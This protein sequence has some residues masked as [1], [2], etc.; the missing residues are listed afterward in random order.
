MGAERPKER[1]TA[2]Q[3]TAKKKAGEKIVCCTAYDYPGALC[4]DAAGVDLVLVGDSL[5]NVIAGEPTTLRVT[6]RQMLYH[7][8]LVD[9]GISSA[10]LVADMPFL[11]FS[12]GETEAVRN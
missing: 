12:L 9:S 10:M 2:A 1:F 7:T 5:G 3:I 8:E 6:M 11:S 4:C